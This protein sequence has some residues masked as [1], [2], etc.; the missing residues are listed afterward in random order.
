MSKRWSTSVTGCRR[1]LTPIALEFWPCG[2][3][4]NDSYKLLKNALLRGGYKCFYNLERPIQ[5]PYSNE[6][7]DDLYKLYLSSSHTGPGYTDLLLVYQFSEVLGVRTMFTSPA[8][9]PRPTEA[10]I[11]PQAAFAY[12]V[13]GKFGNWVRSLVRD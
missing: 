2:M 13:E 10:V 9:L 3:S 6:A 4:K 8:R 11:V 7:L 12:Q 5:I 1:I